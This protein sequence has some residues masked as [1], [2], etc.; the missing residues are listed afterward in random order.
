MEF[1]KAFPKTPGNTSAK[2]FCKYGYGS[3]IGYTRTEIDGDSTW[4]IEQK[5]VC[6]FLVR[7]ALIF[8]C[9]KKT[10]KPAQPELSKSKVPGTFQNRCHGI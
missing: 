3:K 9:F 4:N 7:Q 1:D 5:D 6:F 8:T 10:P 2:A